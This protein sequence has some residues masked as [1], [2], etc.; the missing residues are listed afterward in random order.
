MAYPHQLTDEFK[1]PS[2]YIFI[3][4]EIKFMHYLSNILY[5]INKILEEVKLNKT[6]IFK[7]LFI[8]LILFFWLRRMACGTLASQP[9][10]DPGPLAVSA[11]S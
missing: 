3:V 5:I 11:E 9:G 8:F 1:L 4:D 10:I 7:I 6:I 2:I